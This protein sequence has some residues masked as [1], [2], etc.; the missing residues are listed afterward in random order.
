MAIWVNNICLMNYLISQCPPLWDSLSFARDN[1]LRNDVWER[2]HAFFLAYRKVHFISHSSLKIDFKG[3][4]LMHQDYLL[5]QLRNV[6]VFSNV[7]WSAVLQIRN[8]MLDNFHY[9]SRIFWN[10]SLSS[11]VLKYNYDLHV[12]Y[13]TL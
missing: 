3:I 13:S 7:F 2:N 8:Q 4:K 6:Q 9:F 11:E 1:F 5:W 12:T 10:I